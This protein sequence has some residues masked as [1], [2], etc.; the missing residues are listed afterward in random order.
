MAEP[1]TTAASVTT[2]TLL[3]YKVI[4]GY[5][6]TFNDDFQSYLAKGWHPVGGISVTTWNNNIYFAQLL[7]KPAN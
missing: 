6:E 3:K 5:K 4:S 7:A 1:A 2:T